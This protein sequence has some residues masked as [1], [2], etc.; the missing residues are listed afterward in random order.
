MQVME[1]EM[2]GKT[3]QFKAGMKFIQKAN[4]KQFIINE[5]IRVDVGLTLMIGNIMEGDV[6]ALCDALL[7]MNEGMDPRVT[8]NTIDEYLEDEDTDIETLFEKV[9]DFFKM[10]NCTKKTVQKLEEEKKEKEKEKQKQ[11]I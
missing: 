4:K 8:E 5:G 2:N 9:I 6:M 11:K 3:Y 10:S 1:L 7:L